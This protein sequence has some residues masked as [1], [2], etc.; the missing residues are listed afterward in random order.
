MRDRCMGLKSEAGDANA[1]VFDDGIRE[2]DG[3]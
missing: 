3:R 2:V 1:E